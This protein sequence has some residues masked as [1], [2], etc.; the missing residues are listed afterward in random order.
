MYVDVEFRFC[1]FFEL[2]FLYGYFFLYSLIVN[3]MC[4]HRNY[5][6]QIFFKRNRF[7]VTYR[8]NDRDYFLEFGH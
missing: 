4:V 6:V 1:F 2:A 3:D 5:A 8:Q 7:F